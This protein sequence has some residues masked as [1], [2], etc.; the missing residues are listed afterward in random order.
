LKKSEYDSKDLGLRGS[1]TS[2]KEC[3]VPNKNDS[4]SDYS[5]YDYED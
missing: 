1:D 5:E 2:K 4:S 3:E